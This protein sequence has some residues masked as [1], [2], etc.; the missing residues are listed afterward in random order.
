MIDKR[1][2]LR[3]LSSFSGLLQ[4]GLL[5]DEEAKKLSAITIIYCKTGDED[6]LYDFLDTTVFKNEMANKK[7]KELKEEL[8]EQ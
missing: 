3:I 7:A 6:M 1:K 2:G 4:M 8:Y 5:T